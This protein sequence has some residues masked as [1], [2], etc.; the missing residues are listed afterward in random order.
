M[1]WCDTSSV[2]EHSETVL[3]GLDFLLILFYVGSHHSSDDHYCD[4]REVKKIYVFHVGKLRH[5]EKM[6]LFG[7]LLL[8]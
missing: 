8:P 7:S 6:D 1:K 3:L 4:H 5:R 2:V